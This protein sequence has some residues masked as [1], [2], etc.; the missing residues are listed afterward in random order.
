MTSNIPPLVTIVTASYKKFDHIFDTINSVI[1]QDYQN[2][3]YIIADDGSP[4]FPEKDIVDY[5]NKNAPCLDYKINHSDVNRGTVKNINQA[6]KNSKGD[7]VFP[8][9]CG[10]AFFSKDVVSRIVDRFLATKAKLIVT[11]RLFHN[12]HKPICLLPHYEDRTLI[13]SYDT[14]Q[15]QYEAF[16]TGRAYVMA[17]GS[18][19]YYT[20]EILEDLGYFD[21]KY[22]LWEDGPFLA[23]YLYR[24]S[25]TFAYDIISIWYEYGGMSTNK[26][27]KNPL[28]LNDS[29]LFDKTDRMLH[30]D[31]IHGKKFVEYILAIK[32]AQK[33]YE[34]L[35]VY[36]SFPLIVTGKL[37]RKLI[38]RQRI[39]TDLK[40]IE[41]YNITQSGT[42]FYTK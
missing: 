10:D 26:E 19:M 33:W 39:E 25:L 34:K 3:E 9:S 18:I 36:L 21:E 2:I 16:I 22:V 42:S 6:F 15:K 27:T 7:Y 31:E 37:V 38:E 17:S 20:R 28:L 1:E 11:T 30:I 14:N 35:M 41:D 13:Q 23:K 24:Y 5:I 32:N 40:K 4:N 8:L 12:N 29:R